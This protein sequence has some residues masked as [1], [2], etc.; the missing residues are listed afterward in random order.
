MGEH[1]SKKISNKM[2][3]FFF[4]RSEIG[5]I[6]VLENNARGYWSGAKPH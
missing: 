3:F 5:C 2:S 4:F 6:F 1:I